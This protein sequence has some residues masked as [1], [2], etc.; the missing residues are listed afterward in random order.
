MS[1]KGCLRNVS[2]SESLQYVSN[3]LQRPLKSTYLYYLRDA[4]EF[5]K[6]IR[7]PSRLL[8]KVQTGLCLSQICNPAGFREKCEQ[9][10]EECC[11]QVPTHRSRCW[12]VIGIRA[13][14]IWNFEQTEV[15][16]S[17]R[18]A[19]EIFLLWTN[20]Q[21]TLVFFK[22]SSAWLG[23]SLLLCHFSNSLQPVW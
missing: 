20:V 21:T 10:V 6:A 13:V 19:S 5:E 18:C 16:E 11:Q 15:I 4:A 7:I 14:V 9:W 12:P 2:H 1:F 8:L 22:N 17:Y 23:H 3:S